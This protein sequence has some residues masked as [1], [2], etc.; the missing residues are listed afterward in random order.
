MVP[1]SNMGLK[2]ERYSKNPILAPI[3][4]HFWESKM[5]FNPAAILKN[6]R[7]YLIYR[8]RGSDEVNGILVSRLGLAILKEDGVTVERRYEK[9]VYEPKEWY[10]RA[11]CEDPRI[12][13][14]D[15]QYYLLYTAYEGITYEKGKE[16]INIAMASTTDFFNWKRS[17]N[18]L[19]PESLHSYQAKKNGVLF[20]KKIKGCYVLYYRVHPDVYIAYSKN[21]ENP[22]WF[23][24]KV[25]FGPR[26]GLWDCWKIGA[27][28]PPIELKKG[29]LLIYHGVDRE[30]PLRRIKVGENTETPEG[31]YRVGL[32]I[33]DKENPER[34]LYRSEEPIL[35][36]EE[37]Y[38]KEGLV[39]NVVFPCGA[40]VIK[41]TLFVYYGGADTVV[42]VA[43]CKIS[44]IEKLL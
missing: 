18:L 33:I 31:V 40:V 7:V 8:A 20:P 29:W 3:K 28:P 41:D 25:I 9:P 42:G 34:I 44:E 32:V 35:E 2:L 16:R 37:I 26:K 1:R 36:P 21:L 12:T 38:E 23:G 13:E 30:R 5:V 4:E 22:R 14:I 43:T 24:H 15:G 17:D 39:P 6:N 19:L 10:E 27:G 11:G